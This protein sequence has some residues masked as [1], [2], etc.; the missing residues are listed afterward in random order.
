L[1][2]V[3]RAQEWTAALSRWCE[4]QPDLVLYRGQCLIHRAEIMQLHGAWTDAMNEVQR[5]IDRFADSTPQLMT[6]AA[7]YLR[8]ELHRLRGEFVKAEKAYREANQF[9]RE[10]QPGL[11][12]LRVAQGQV[13]T[14]FAAIRRALD[15]AG[16]PM[17]RARLLGAYVEIALARGER[18]AARGAADELS[19]IAVELDA[20]FL[21]ASAAHAAGS[22][23][24]AE[25]DA[26]S[27]LGTLRHGWAGWQL[28]E[29][30]YEAARVR[31][32]IGLACRA[33]GDEDSA[34]MELDAARFVFQQLSAAPDVAR[35]E[36]LSRLTAP[37]AAGGLTAREEEVLALV[38]TGKTNRAIAAELVV[39][40]KTVASHLSHI[41][42]KLGLSSRAAATAYA[43]EHG[44][45]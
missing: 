12:L 14:G 21:R 36:Q 34:E 26:R 32:L 28:F 19:R 42:T 37:A 18:E 5:A 29:A 1:F 33:L 24:L 13:D 25:G 27:A 35:V 2:D 44:L 22:V 40:E 3:R 10:P 4:A 16:D 23:L 20:P 9:G 7:L 6:G 43:Y 41:F 45:V 38:A 11:A 39:S 15:E 31:V 30:P 8:A 17:T